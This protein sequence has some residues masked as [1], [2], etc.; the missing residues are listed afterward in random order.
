MVP[1]TQEEGRGGP[2]IGAILFV[3][4]I[5]GC[6]TKEVFRANNRFDW[7]TVPELANEYRVQVK[8]VPLLARGTAPPLLA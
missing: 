4:S 1:G 3:G 2:Y 8:S 7:C 6:E 5:Q